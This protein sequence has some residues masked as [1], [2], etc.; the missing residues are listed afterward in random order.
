M[1]APECIEEVFEQ[2]QLFVTLDEQRTTR[3]KDFVTRADVDVRKRF[4]Q[5]E[6]STDRNIEANPS[7]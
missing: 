7:Q 6:D 1:V 4:C 5:V 2:T 3:V